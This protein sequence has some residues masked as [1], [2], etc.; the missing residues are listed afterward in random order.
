[1]DEHGLDIPEMPFK[2]QVGTKA[3]IADAAY[4]DL[5]GVA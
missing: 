5:Y 4:R 2:P 3:R 1:M